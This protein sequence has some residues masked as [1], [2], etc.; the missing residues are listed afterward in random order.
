MHQ[1]ASARIAA[2]Q[3]AL[4]T[5]ASPELRP[6]LTHDI[7]AAQRVGGV[8]RYFAEL[9]KAL[10][11]D[12]VRS[13]VIAP[14]Y[15]CDALQDATDVVGRHLPRCATF[16]G[17]SRFASQVSRAVEPIAMTRLG[18]GAERPLVH[19]TYYSSSAE[20]G[21]FPIVVTVYD[22]IHERYPEFFA[23]GTDVAEKK[24]WWCAHADGIIAI[25]HHTKRELVELLDV[26]PERVTVT[27]LAPVA[28]KPNAQTLERLS[29]ERPY[30]LYVGTRG[31]H[32]NFARFVSAFAQSSS[33][34]ENVRVIAFGGG[35]ARPSEKAH[36]DSLGSRL[37]VSFVTGDDADLAA[38]Y[39]AAAAFVCPSLDEGFGLPPLE[40]MLH[41]C[42]VAAA[43][44]GAVP[45]VVDA[46]AI[47]FEP[48]DLDSIASAVDVVVTGSP[49]VRSELVGRARRHAAEF[50]W[51]RTARATVGAYEAALRRAEARFG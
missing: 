1:S 37:D 3:P 4:E 39:A 36:I 21:R 25:S 29:G 43:S 50:T 11:R 18:S 44:A 12:G 30:V 20:P 16:R 34:R 26:D 9:H 38:H 40:A 32:K 10:R 35:P 48:T 13:T 45:E 5:V 33:A 8:S 28:V 23:A 22:M 31:G 17:A 42:P 27:Q 19:P 7:F 24:R 46:A 47:L 41:G 15:L 2:A 14:I 51:T 49:S 6:I